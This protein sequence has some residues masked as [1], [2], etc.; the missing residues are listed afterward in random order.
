M[1]KEAVIPTDLI[2]N[3]IRRSNLSKQ[4]STSTTGV[5]ESKPEN[6]INKERG[7]TTPSKNPDR[8]SP[9]P[10]VFFRNPNTVTYLDTIQTARAAKKL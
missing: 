3:Q 9:P 8:V 6:E 10:D 2:L 7:F 5:F 4:G 1:S